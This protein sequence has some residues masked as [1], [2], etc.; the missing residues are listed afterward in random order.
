MSSIAPT[1]S[2]T[3]TSLYT[4]NSESKSRIPTKTL[5][6][7]E[8]FKLLITQL[9]SQDPMNPQSDS[10]FIA[11]M[12]QFSALEQS[13]AM[14]SDMSKLQANNLIG[15]E[16]T[17]TGPDNS[18]IRGVVSAVNLNGDS[19]KIIVQNQAYDIDAVTSVSNHSFSTLQ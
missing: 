18:E 4:G 7:D 1:T 13:K 9:T 3:A 14:Q 12:A 11:Q 10:E 6:Q 19:P 15:R 2:A 16:V 17:L 8:F 5:G